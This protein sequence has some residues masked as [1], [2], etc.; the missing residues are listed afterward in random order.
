MRTAL[1]LLFLAARLSAQSTEGDVVNSIT[2][3]PVQEARLSA[4]PFGGGKELTT[5]T[6][7]TG[8]FSFPVAPSQIAVIAT[9]HNGYISTRVGC[10][11][12]GGVRIR[13]EPA[14]AISG[15]IKD[16]DGFP[17]EGVGVQAIRDQIVPGGH[18]QQI[19]V[20]VASDD[21]GRYR[22]KSNGGGAL[23]D[24]H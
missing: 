11:A 22:L 1:L 23:L 4:N 19:M 18:R 13:L 14:A 20:T 16:E 3:V 24:S 17:V 7:A 5:I 15:T 21:L 2:G 12:E 8:H 10:C 9:V 6:S